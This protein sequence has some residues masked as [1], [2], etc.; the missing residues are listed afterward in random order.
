MRAQKQE[1]GSKC[2]TFDRHNLI[3]VEIDEA[4]QLLK[5]DISS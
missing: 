1:N 5:V 3:A 4:T 2:A